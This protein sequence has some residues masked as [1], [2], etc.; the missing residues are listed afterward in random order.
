MSDYPHA[1]PL[2]RA[3]AGLRRVLRHPRWSLEYARRLT[4]RGHESNNDGFALDHYREYTAAEEDAV[5][6]I[7]DL[8]KEDYRF[9]RDSVWIPDPEA[10]DETAW[11][12]RV[13]LL[14]TI[15]VAV[16]ALR[17][18]VMIETG[19]ERGYSAAVALAAMRENGSGRL[20]SVDLPRL[21]VDPDTFTGRLIPAHLRDRWE[22]S[23]GPSRQILPK[24]TAR[25]DEVDIFLHDSDHS[26]AAQMAE[27]RIVW[28][29]LRPGGLLVSDD[30]WNSA[31]VD[32]AREIAEE[33]LLIPR[34][35]SA[36][37]VGL[38]RKH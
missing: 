5:R 17:P 11:S 32:F 7:L 15:G 14:R 12:S 1:S 4:E 20:F 18:D 23:E 34:A 10:D 22:L 13:V 24:L 36:D 25:L 30:V 31:L 38:L 2:L 28:P 33:P 9:L 29:V 8:S 37:A 26:Y 35:G 19:V 16:R 21:Q 27:Y 6:R 3:G